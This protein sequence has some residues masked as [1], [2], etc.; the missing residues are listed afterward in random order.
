MEMLIYLCVAERKIDSYFPNGQFF[1]QGYYSP[2][3]L[4]ASNRM[5]WVISLCKRAYSD[6]TFFF[7]VGSQIHPAAKI[8]W[9][10]QLKYEIKYKD[11]QI[12][13][14]EISLRN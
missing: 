9:A 4:N 1:L 10:R 6:T 3:C 8:L 5:G 2:Y 12:I 13:V 11:I 14:F 7:C